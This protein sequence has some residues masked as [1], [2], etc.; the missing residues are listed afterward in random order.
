MVIHLLAPGDNGGTKVGF[1]VGKSVGNSVRRHR[2]TRQ[3]RHLMRSRLD[4]L[5]TGTQLVVRARPEAA[6]VSSALLGRDIDRI[7]VRLG[8]ERSDVDR[9]GVDAGRTV[10]DQP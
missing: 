5:P 6:G 2:V 3:L 10:V 1:V 9:S 4:R 8:V 7:L